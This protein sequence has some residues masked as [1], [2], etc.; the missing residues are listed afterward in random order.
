MERTLAEY[1]AVLQ[2]AGLDPITTEIGDAVD[3]HF[4]SAEEYH[5]KYLQKNPNGYDCHA[6]TGFFLP[7]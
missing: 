1:S 5:Q 4:W 3:H 2:A 7:A 6:H